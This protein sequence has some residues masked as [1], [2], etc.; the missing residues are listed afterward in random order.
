[1]NLVVTNTW[2]GADT[3]LYHE[4]PRSEIHCPITNHENP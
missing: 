4:R 3:D 1:L 2:N